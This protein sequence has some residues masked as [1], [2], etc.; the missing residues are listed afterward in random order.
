M[1]QWFNRYYL[2]KFDQCWI[3]DQR[4]NINLAGELSHG[5]IP[6]NAVYIGPLSRFTDAKTSGAGYL[7]I[8]LSGPEPQ[9]SLLEQILSAQLPEYKGPV[10]IV[11]GLP[12]ESAKPANTANIEWF[13]HLPANTLQE[14]MERSALVICRSGY[15]TVMDL[16]RIQKRAILIPT[17]GQA[18]QEYLAAYLMQQG[19]FLSVAQSTFD[20][21][22]DLKKVAQFSSGFPTLDY[23]AFKEVIHQF[24]L[25]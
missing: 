10:K 21:D 22:R 9:R 13:N 20:L 16:V 1:V 12:S 18:E 5:S 4:G 19:I 6:P 23:G 11:R 17:P 15:S 25:G 3:P 7:L 8:V 24:V 14:M 2:N